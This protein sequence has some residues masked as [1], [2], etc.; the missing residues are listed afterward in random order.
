MSST[1]I[2]V[3]SH[4][5]LG[6]RHRVE[7]HHSY[8]HSL[9]PSISNRRFLHS[10]APV[11][12]LR[13]CLPHNSAPCASPATNLGQ[14]EGTGK[15]DCGCCDLGFSRGRWPCGPNISLCCVLQTAILKK[16]QQYPT[17]KGI[18]KWLAVHKD[19]AAQGSIGGGGG[20]IGT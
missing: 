12:R 10:T 13:S 8:V 15:G 7:L 19:A 6:W 5:V 4:S 18:A 20:F 11:H 1:L 3:F 17:C 16:E 2:Y 14:N 9:M